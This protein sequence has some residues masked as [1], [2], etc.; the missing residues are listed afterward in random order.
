[1]DSTTSMSITSLLQN[2]VPVVES[3]L[4]QKQPNL[5]NEFLWPHK[6]LV[7]F[8]T[9]EELQEPL[10]DLKGFMEGDE[11]ATARAVEFVKDAC[12]NHGV[13]QVINHGVDQDIINAAHQETDAFFKLP[14]EKKLR[15]KRKP[16]EAYGHSGAHAERFSS[17]LPWKETLS[18][19]YHNNDDSKLVVVDYFKSA[20][21]EDFEHSGSVYQ[22]YC[23]AMKTLS[24]ALFEL[25]GMSLGGTV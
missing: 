24:L 20:F 17:R 5:P 18:F 4:L 3:T 25:L 9:Q 11:V 2:G 19:E 6:D 13:F 21:G 16:G 23:E 15:G 10:I 12:L 22:R 14:S 1:M 7:S 8:H